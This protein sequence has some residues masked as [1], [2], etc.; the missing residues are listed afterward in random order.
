MS[1]MRK[2]TPIGHQYKRK[3]SCN[4]WGLFV[5]IDVIDDMN[6]SHKLFPRFRDSRG[7]VYEAQSGTLVPVMLEP[8]ITPP[9]IQ[10]VDMS[11]SCNRGYV[12]R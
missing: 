11:K 10:I 12:P 3:I 7:D 1:K 6:I 2:E 5:D 4:N 9:V 8:G